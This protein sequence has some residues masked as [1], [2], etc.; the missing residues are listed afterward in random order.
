MDYSAGA[1][2]PAQAA[3]PEK[4]SQLYIREYPHRSVAIV[5]SSH[6]LIFRHSSS[7]SVETLGNGPSFPPPP[8]S[9]RA[10][11]NGTENTAPKCIV[12]FTPLGKATLD[13]YRPLI[14]RPI[15]GTLGL[16]SAEGDVF[17]S[18]VTR[19]S[20]VA[21]VRPSETVERIVSVE[22]FCLSSER[23]DNVGSLDDFDA[24]SADQ[25]GQ[26]GYRDMSQRLVHPCMELRKLLSNGTFYY[27][28]DFD[29]TNRLQDR[30]V[31]Q[32]TC[33]MIDGS[34]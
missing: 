16:I 11:G 24:D 1:Q 3:D 15:F 20:R 33:K 27:S 4:S 32:K 26:A 29:V 19:A 6:A 14:P 23:W 7:T 13:D 17:L 25:S 21:T 28:T 30:Y 8:S 10:R 31:L 9:T 34:R 12:E 18:V 5:S 22:F 2:Y